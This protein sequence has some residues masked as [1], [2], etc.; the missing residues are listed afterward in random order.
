MKLNIIKF[1]CEKMYIFIW[2]NLGRIIVSFV[3]IQMQMWIVHAI[4]IIMKMKMKINLKCFHSKGE[5]QERKE[6]NE[7]Y[8]N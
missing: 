1:Y 8:F 7:S 5:N 4:T 2:N 6:R 3:N